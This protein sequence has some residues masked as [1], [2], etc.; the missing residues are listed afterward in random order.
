MDLGVCLCPILPEGRSH[1]ASRAGALD[2]GSPT[3]LRSAHDP[4]APQTVWH[5]S[6]ARASGRS[7]S[8]VTRDECRRITELGTQSNHPQTPTML[9]FRAIPSLPSGR[10]SRIPR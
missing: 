2:F 9:A 6:P 8:A 10:R 7:R 3:I 1:P 4:G 5:G